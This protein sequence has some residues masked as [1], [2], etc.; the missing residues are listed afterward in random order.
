MIGMLEKPNIQPP[1]LSNLRAT[2]SPAFG[3]AALKRGVQTTGMDVIERFSQKLME[4]PKLEK[5]GAFNPKL[6]NLSLQ[7]WSARVSTLFAFYTPQTILAFTEEKHKWET[8]GR[9]LLNWTGTIGIVA[10]CKHDKYGINALF[11][12]FLKPR[13]NLSETVKEVTGKL[14]NA[15]KDSRTLEPIVKE[16]VTRLRASITFLGKWVNSKRFKPEFFDFLSEKAYINLANWTELDENH[17]DEMKNI[18]KELEAQKVKAGLTE[19]EKYIHEAIPKAMNR[20]S[21]FKF[22]AIGLST[23][24][25]AFF[26]GKVVMDLV[27][28]FIAPFDHDFDA[29]K[30]A[31]LGRGKKDKTL[32]TLNLPSPSRL[33]SRLARSQENDPFTVPPLQYVT[34]FQPFN[35]AYEGERRP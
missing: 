34:P 17:F 16:S 22:A 6:W 24:A 15:V 31:N 23:A 18:W 2:S 10:L 30:Y 4:N 3:N 12:P 11:N 20:I 29:E 9:N 19:S 25:L 14:E 26:I 35:P 21:S 13:E 8:L 28:Q 32:Q 27:Y 1:H 7:D 5:W 33:P